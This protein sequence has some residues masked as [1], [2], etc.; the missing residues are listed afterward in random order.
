MP[1]MSLNNIELNNHMLAAIYGKSL[2]DCNSVPLKVSENLT[3]D[4]LV[5]HE[6]IN[7]EKKPANIKLI[8]DILSA[9]KINSEK[10]MMKEFEKNVDFPYDITINELKP[11]F[12]LVLGESENNGAFSG[13][14]LFYEIRDYSGIP[15]LSAPAP[16]LLA[17]D[18]ESKM[19]LW[20]SLRSF[21]NL[22]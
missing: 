13:R 3:K 9:C 1:F 4:V 10:V 21:F 22:D 20:N 17:S 6:I 11:S 16:H 2:I 5:F 19:K 18:K 14:D 15:L 7:D 8:R 12:I